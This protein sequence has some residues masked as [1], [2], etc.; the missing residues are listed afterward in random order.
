MRDYLRLVNKH[1]EAGQ[2]VRID[3]DKV[4]IDK[5]NSRA[6]GKS[7]GL[8]LADSTAGAFFNALEPDKFGNTEPRY[9]QIMAAVLYRHEGTLQGY[10]LKIVPREA[11][12]IVITRGNLKWL[13]GLK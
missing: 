3:F 10:G 9:L 11:L 1:Q 6:P 4:P 13:S 2:E 5:L 12:P 7:M 8:Q